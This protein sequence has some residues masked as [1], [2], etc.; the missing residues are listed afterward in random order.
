[1]ALQHER[2]TVEGMSCDHCRQAVE[3]AVLAVTGVA[4][5][6]VD[7]AAKLLSVDYDTAKCGLAEIRAAID[8]AGFTAA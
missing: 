4:A 2:I 8:D 6:K 3:K 1:M 7:L 5:A